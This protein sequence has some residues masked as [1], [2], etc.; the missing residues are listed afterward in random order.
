MG[1]HINDD[2][3][4]H[5][6]HYTNHPSGIECIEIAEHHNF[7]IG[8]AIKYLWR[9]GLKNGESNVKDLKKAVW[10]INRE[11]EKCSLKN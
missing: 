4:N 1:V 11:I 9:Q 5:P 3:I 8:N 2:E 6:S 10:Y 7:R